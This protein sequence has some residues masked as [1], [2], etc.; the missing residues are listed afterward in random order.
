MD[1]D[2]AIEK[3][4]KEP[5]SYLMA[6]A[7]GSLWCPDCVMT[8]EHVLETAEFKAW[9]VDN[10]VILVDID[11]PNFPNTT[12]SACLLT[13]ATGRTSDGYVS[14]RGT[15][16]TNE[17]ERFQSGAGYLSRHMATASA[18]KAALERNRSLV[19][20][21]TLE[22]GWNNPDR[23]NQN[24]TGIPN[25]FALRRDGS[26]AGTFETFDAIGPSEFK[27]AYLKRFSELVAMG[28]G[29]DDGDFS[30]R[31]WQT[32]ED[33]FSGEGA[34]S[35]D[36][37]PLDLA[38]TY[39]LA[40][41]T[42]EAA[43][44]TVTA[45]GGEATATLSIIAVSGGEA[46]TVATATGPLS[47]GI[48]VSCTMTPKETYYV[49][50]AGA[51]EGALAA[52]SDAAFGTVGYPLRGERSPIANPYENE[53]TQKAAKAVL[54]LYAAD[55][56][57]LAGRLELQLKKNGKISAK[58][59]DS[60]RRLASLSGTWNADIS[61]DGTATAVLEKG[62]W[63]LELSIT[64]SGA[65]SAS[66]S[67]AKELASGECAL[68]ESYADWT[69]NYAVALPLS[70]ASGAWQGDAYMTLSIGGDKASVT[71]GKVK[72]KVFLPDGKKL[73]GT[74]GV[75]GRDAD[76]G[77][78]PVA[79]TSGANTFRASVLVRRNA[80]S[81]PTRRAV[82]ADGDAAAVWSGD[83]VEL[84]CGV[85]GSLV[86]AGDSLLE[87]ADA[88]SL[89]F[90]PDASGIGE[91]GK[92]G[93]LNG[94]LYDGGLFAV[95]AQTIYPVEKVS[96]FAFKLNRKTGVFTGKTKLSFSG[97]DKV[98]AKYSGVILPDWFSDCECQEDADTVVPMTFQPFGAGQCIYS[99]VFGGKR[100]KRSFPV[101]LG[102]KPME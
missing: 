49:K 96:G 13:Y 23:T 3:Y 37:A 48:S 51:A 86:S 47:G 43:V 18:A 46:S 61:A 81:A 84:R 39:A 59:S 102:V 6:I 19:G 69:G 67:G 101:S 76:F 68:A 90:V 71:R 60:S 57:G 63:T 62:G 92:Y 70:D 87:R 28:E 89:A 21:N 100:V 66:L 55:G 79:K 78:V 35:G 80:A 53:W 91:D 72:Y 93:T 41:I 56:S 5:D 58:I 77:V 11:V 64:A 20:R 14:G 31:S 17:L 98:S 50:L 2:V 7:S 32:T 30:N 10:K 45:Q 40:A 38:D 16:A 33:S 74:T 99:G 22:G 27:E 52:D 75:T 29:E 24:R 85:F 9:A 26:L 34:L 44:Q 8:D 83:G 15:L 4:K 1:L 54:P 36:L 65:V 82:V 94:V 95:T 12:N 25:F 42:T 88:E 97:K 73:S